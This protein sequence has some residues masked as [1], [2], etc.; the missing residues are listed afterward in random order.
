M[1]LSLFPVSVRSETNLIVC[2]VVAGTR[3]VRFFCEI[4]LERD[5]QKIELKGEFNLT[6]TNMYFTSTLQLFVYVLRPIP[7]PCNAS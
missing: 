1:L 4:I 6:D 2:L 5:K 3:Q 7:S